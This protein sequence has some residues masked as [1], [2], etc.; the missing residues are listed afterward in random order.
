MWLFPVPF[1]IG[2]LA[3]SESGNLTSY[4]DKAMKTF[5]GS[6]LEHNCRPG[7]RSCMARLS[8]V[9][10][11]DP[12]M[13][14]CKATWRELSPRRSGPESIRTKCHTPQALQETPCPERARCGVLFVFLLAGTPS[15][16]SPTQ[17]MSK[18]RN[19]NFGQRCGTGALPSIVVST[20][21]IVQSPRSE[22][23]LARA[24]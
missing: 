3:G 19:G 8:N 22:N 7:P 2:G 13:D 23:A 9:N 16:R 24:L 12:N 15:L 6:P 17:G 20:S 4:S 5:A 10:F 18:E 1:P 21:H 14:P 11:Q